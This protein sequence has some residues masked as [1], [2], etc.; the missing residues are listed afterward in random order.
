M[1]DDLWYKNA[2]FYCLSVGTYM[3]ANGDGIGDFKGLLR[4]LDYLQGLGIT[5]LWLMPFQPSPGK[6]D[7]YDIAD[8][9]GVD[10]RYGT[11]GDFVEFTHGCQ[12]RGIRVIIDLVVNHT[13]DTHPWFREARSSPDSEY[14]DWYVWADKK[15]ANAGTGMVFPGVQKSTWTRDKEAKAWYFHRFYDFQPDLNTSNPRVQAEILKIMGFWIQL[16]VSGFR[17]DAVPFVIATKGAK[18]RTPVEQYDM[19]RAFREFLQWRQGNAIILAEANVLP[20][21]D[22]EYFGDDGDRMQMMFN[23]HVNQHLFYALASA[24]SR[25]LAKALKATKPRPASAQWGLFLRNHDELDLGRLTKAQRDVVFR[26]FGPDKN[27]QLYGRGIRRRL[28]PM[29]G[30]D[31]RRLELAYSLMCTLP[32]TPVIRYGDEIGMGENLA[33]PERNCARTP[34][35]WSTEPNAGFTESDKPCS[36]IIDKGPYGFEHV[37]VAKQRRDPGS[38]LNWTERI[39]RM[40]KEVPEIG[41]GDFEVIATRDPAVLI[42]RY[43]WCNNSALFV[44]NLDE[45]PRELSFTAG[46]PG[47]AGRHLI[48]LLSEDHSQAYKRGQ[49]RLV[50]EGY[51][52]RWYRVGGLDYLLK[53]SDIDTNAAGNAGHPA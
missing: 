22:M 35:Q 18:V 24:D 52:Y 47:D 2:I 39:I 30:G 26:S 1:I 25:S 21:T 36:P 20:E 40:R 41:W 14:R 5:T 33:L 27:M 12:Q 19:L 23:F 7:G 43:D 3:D 53:R 8:Y 37:N 42:I 28:A 46:L 15:P 49:H 50:I 4:R 9:Y 34:M 29:L 13:S 6:D 10:P 51:G 44:H 48:N 45:K 32:G 31:R 17:M 11:L 38:M 16:G